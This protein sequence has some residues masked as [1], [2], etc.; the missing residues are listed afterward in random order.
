MKILVHRLGGLIDPTADAYLLDAFV[1]GLYGG[2]GQTI[3]WDS[4]REFI[5][6]AAKLGKP[7]I[8]AG[9]LTP[10]N[11]QV[12]IAKVEPYAV[13]VSSGVEVSP[14]V[15]DPIMIRDFI[16]AARG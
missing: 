11:V 15:K 1:P 7:V 6:E 2:T 5:T 13:D 3:D 10:E 12:A 4:A 14:G 8:L 9:G 16:Q